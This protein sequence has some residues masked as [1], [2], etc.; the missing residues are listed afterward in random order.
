MVTTA[1][2]TLPNDAPP[3]GAESDKQKFSLASGRA[4]QQPSIATSDSERGEHEPLRA[5]F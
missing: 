3:S 1:M 2:L 5:S 4:V